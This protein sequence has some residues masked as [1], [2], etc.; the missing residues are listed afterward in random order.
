LRDSPSRI[1][2]FR[3]WSIGPIH[4][5]TQRGMCRSAGGR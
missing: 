1:R 4:P 2:R 3:Q 5:R